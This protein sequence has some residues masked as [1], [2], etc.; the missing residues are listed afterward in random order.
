MSPQEY[1][2]EF[3][4][5]YP[6]IAL[7]YGLTD[8]EAKVYGFIRFYTRTGQ[9]FYWSN[10]DLAR[11]TNC[12]ERTVTRAMEK[13]VYLKLFVSEYDMKAGGGQI[14]FVK[15]GGQNVRPLAKMASRTSQNGEWS[16]PEEV[17]AK[18]TEK[19]LQAINNKE[20]H[21]IEK[22]VKNT[23]DFEKTMA[24]EE[25]PDYL[26]WKNRKEERKA[27]PKTSFLQRGFLSR[28]RPDSPKPHSA[29]PSLSSLT[30]GVVEKLCRELRID[31]KDGEKK[32]TDLVNYCESTGKTYNDYLAALRSFIQRGI[33]KG[34]ILV[35]KTTLE[36][37]FDEGYP[38]SINGKTVKTMAEYIKEYQIWE[39]E[40]GK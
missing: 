16:N 39:R 33:D 14:R 18:K 9:P 13:L 37:M 27:R 30:P 31:L 35:N 19:N 29:Y 15:K 26:E 20:K 5:Y 25:S 12:G 4:P 32:L 17:Q 8:S 23:K 34:D 3:I 10:K 38:V 36:M 24:G 21:N 2:V 28:V 11:I 6:Q 22:I 1:N 40:H 7:D